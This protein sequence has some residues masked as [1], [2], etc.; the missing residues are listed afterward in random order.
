MPRAEHLQPKHGQFTTQRRNTHV[1]TQ[2]LPRLLQRRA[3]L[4]RVVPEVW[5][6]KETDTRVFSPISYHGIAP[7]RLYDTAEAYDF[8]QT[9]DH[10]RDGDL[11]RCQRDGVEVWAVLVSAWPV[12]FDGLDEERQ[13]G[14]FHTLDDVRDLYSLDDG[15]YAKSFD[16]AERFTLR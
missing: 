11:I 14:S 6:D 4:S 8:T 3:P 13:C 1:S 7:D 16:V 5:I 10:F 15:K 12:A 2:L 9:C